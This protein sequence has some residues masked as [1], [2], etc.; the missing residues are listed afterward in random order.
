MASFHSHLKCYS[1]Q[2]KWSPQSAVKSDIR[3]HL[4]KWKI[5][6]VKA[7]KSVQMTLLKVNEKAMKTKSF[8]SVSCFASQVWTAVYSNRGEWHIYRWNIQAGKISDFKEDLWMQS[9][10]K[11]YWNITG[12]IFIAK[13]IILKEIFHTEI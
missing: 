7:D 4:R 10:D 13:A 12:N 9:D 2:T 3:E 5:Q 1:G 11:L 6:S 8:K